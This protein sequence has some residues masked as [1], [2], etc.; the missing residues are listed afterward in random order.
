MA[1][2]PV[3]VR[4]VDTQLAVYR[5]ITS[6][7]A[8]LTDASTAPNEIARERSSPV[9]IELPRLPGLKHDLQSAVWGFRN[10][11]SQQLTNC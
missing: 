4:S 2:L 9:Y 10:G 11:L 8:V 3:A 1:R 7:Q 5:G 6:D